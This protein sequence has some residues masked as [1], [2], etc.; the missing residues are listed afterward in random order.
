MSCF[1]HNPHPP[2]LWSRVSGV[3]ITDLTA[4]GNLNLK[5][6]ETIAMLNKGNILQYK[7]NSSNLTRN[8]RY[9][10][11]INGTW[12]NRTTTWAS[13]SE[14]YTD[15]NTKMLKRVN[16]NNITTDGTPTT[17]PLTCKLNPIIPISNLPAI[18]DNLNPPPVPPPLPPIVT[19][20]SS[21]YLPPVIRPSIKPTVIYDGGNLLCNVIENPCTGQ[22]I[23]SQAN[24]IC[25]PTS[26]SDVPGPI[27]P[28]CYANNIQTWYP[29]QRLVMSNST[30]KWPIN[31]KFIRR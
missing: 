14:Y 28:L 12:T 25:N 31:A 16:F 26:A 22:S 4:D 3:C 30:D 27:Q 24:P 23:I 6:I 21:S 29:R 9:S 11:I 19:D 13:Q 20:G 5:N 1:I 15:P 2:R 17:D 7:K 10:K 18:V 8:Q